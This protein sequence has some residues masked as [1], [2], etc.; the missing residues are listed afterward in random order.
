MKDG[1][2]KFQRESFFIYIDQDNSLFGTYDGFARRENNQFSAEWML[3][4]EGGTGIYENASGNFIEV[5][6]DAEG[7]EENPVFKIDFSG[8]I[9]T[10]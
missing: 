1:T 8:T 10:R 9:L 7:S 2:T 3:T 6:G 4:V 5:I